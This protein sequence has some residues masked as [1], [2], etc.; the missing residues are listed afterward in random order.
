MM[1][2]K[3]QEIILR[4]CC[5]FLIRSSVCLPETVSE[6]DMSVIA[7][8]T[9][10]FSLDKLRKGFY[11]KKALIVFVCLINLLMPSM[12]W[13]EEKAAKLEEIVVTGEKLVTPTKQPDE[14]V[15][16]G[17]EVTQKGMEIQGIKGNVSIYE[18]IDILPGVSV[19]S[20]DPYGLSAESRFIRVRGVR[21]Y[22]GA[23]TVEGVPNW[24]GNPI[25]PR[26]YLYDTKNLQGIAVYKG[27]IP[28]DFSTGVGSRGGAIELKPRWPED[29]F[30]FDFD[31]AFGSYGYHRSYFRL[32]SG[33]LPGVDT[34]LSASYSLTN[35]DKWK[36]S[37][38]LG[39]RNNFN[40]ML[41]RPF[42]EKDQIKV[43]F[44][45]ND[46]DQNLYMP[47]KYSETQDLENNY[48][49]DYNASLT[50]IKSQDVNY[51]E[52]NRGN[53]LNKDILSIIPV[54][55]NDMF[56]LTFKPYYS[57]ENTEIL[58]GSTSQGGLITKRTRDIERYGLISQI[59]SN[60]SFATA[61][62]GY[63]V[64]SNDMTIITQN[65]DPVSFA[66]KG[67]GMYTKNDGN[68]ILHSPYFK[69]SGN[70]SD[71]DWQG[72]LKYFY[73]HDPASQG[74][75]SASPDYK[76]VLAPDLYRE[77]K[78]YDEILPSA[79]IGY[80]VTDDLQLY[81]SY[82][83]NQVR[84]Y[85]YVPIIS[86]YNQNRSTFQKAGVTLNDLFNGYDMEVSDNY[87]LGARIRKKWFDLT[88]AVF[89]SKHNNLL[90][91]VYDPRVNLSYQQNIGKA[92]GC[93]VEVETNI[94]FNKDITFFF[95]PTYTLLTYDDNLTYQGKTMDTK[96]NQVVDVPAWLIKTGL[97]YKYDDFEIT[98]MI[99]YLT[100]RYGDVEHKE[101]LGDYFV[102]DLNLSYT[103]RKLSFTEALKI[104]L[105]LHNLL[106]RKYVSGINASDDNRSGNTSYYVGAPFTAVLALS[107]E[108]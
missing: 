104:S 56:N 48:I 68:G 2:M 10:W 17:S 80:Y 22:V 92:T 83:R 101:K 84:P 42:G 9:F 77:A 78:N 95:N 67:Y 39:P 58:N 89:Y 63:W 88:P 14:T 59:Q 65:F 12:A 8:T 7:G 34:N 21:G 23:M 57:L 53:H 108:L 100:D 99:R 64:E 69:L 33:K 5:P 35:A 73:Y 86:L 40:V 85:S 107:M 94:H 60:F 19:E 38:D 43:W 44:N 15:Y 102:T 37:G 36:G 28:A 87:E 61:S 32:D 79:G 81:T 97:I 1:V 91:T 25:G 49:K 16:T 13:T 76:L 26:D 74:Y 103:K 93:G 41:K 71:F 90:T 27:A 96:D 6:P 47:L 51:Y 50:G 20:P 62:L 52:Y 24:G 55:L 66:N 30:G 75:T 46:V 72:G 29:K 4:H 105:Q 70:I 3:N 98:P 31:Q 18:A 106:D 54:T 45:Y 11:M 82:A